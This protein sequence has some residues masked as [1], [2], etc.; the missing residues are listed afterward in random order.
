MMDLL[1]LYGQIATLR[2][3]PQDVPGTQTVLVLTV[4]GYLLVNLVVTLVL[5]QVPGPWIIHLGIDV[6][7]TLLWYVVLLRAAGR[8]ERFLQTA[9]AVFGYQA[10]LSPLWIGTGWLIRRFQDDVNWL[11]PVTLLGLVLVVWMISANAQILKAALEWSTA[12]CVGLVILQIIVGQALILTL[13]PVPAAA[14]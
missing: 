3:G 5:P 11:F 4:A 14:S 12:A 6:V 10:V 9:S 2:K 13:F 7:F 8:P 1:R